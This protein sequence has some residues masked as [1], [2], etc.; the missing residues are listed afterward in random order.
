[1]KKVY[2]FI[3][4]LLSM[5]FINVLSVSANDGGVEMYRMYN[6]NSC[7]VALR[8]NRLDCSSGRSRCL[9]NVQSKCG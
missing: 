2:I 6:P 9:Q 8:G 7:R 5:V 1:M 3:T 4:V